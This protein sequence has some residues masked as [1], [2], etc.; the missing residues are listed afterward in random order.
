MNELQNHKTLYRHMSLSLEQRLA[1]ASWFENRV[2]R[3]V[4]QQ[5]S[6]IRELEVTFQAADLGSVL[7]SSEIFSVLKGSAQDI[8]ERLF[9][10]LAEVRLLAWA[11]GQGYSNI[12]KLQ[13]NAGYPTPDFLMKRDDKVFMAEAKH[14]RARDYLVYFV[15]DRLEGLALKTDTLKQFGLSV[16]TG[17]K[18]AQKRDDIL[19]DRPYW[20]A[21]TRR[22]LV[23]EAFLELLQAL[24][25]TPNEQ[26]AI[27]DGL[28]LVKRNDL[29]SPGR[30]FPVL[31]GT[32]NQGKTTE[33]CLSRLQA[34]LLDK[35]KQIKG[36]MAA[37]RTQV[38][39]AIVFF[40]GVDEWS[41]EWSVIWEALDANDEAARKQIY[42]IKQEADELIGIPFELIVGRY[43]KNGR[44]PQ[45][46]VRYGSIDYVPFPC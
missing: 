22:Q 12:A 3:Y 21:N 4:L 18:Y 31:K 8:D 6:W 29:I 34:E 1:S 24:E 35:L 40:S 46:E 27:L 41:P 10:A 32:P 11:R 28:F 7:Y 43:Q 36:F 23:E 44:G 17:S 39:R 19:K 33:R 45:G 5:F 13:T 9:D 38:D 25:A 16:E 42:A 2:I 20:V 15:A 14:F 26:Q 30:V 37:K